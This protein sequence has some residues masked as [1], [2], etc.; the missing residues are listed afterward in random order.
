MK[1]LMNL[2]KAILNKKEQK[3]INGGTPRLVPEDCYMDQCPNMCSRSGYTYN[4][5]T[6]LCCSSGADWGHELDLA[7][8]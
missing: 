1:S 5:S 4:A 8:A 2:G 6:G 7:L 3:E